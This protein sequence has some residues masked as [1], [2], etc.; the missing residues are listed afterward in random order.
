MDAEARYHSIQ[1]AI[2]LLHEARD[3]LKEAKAPRATEKVRRALKSA[4]GALRHADGMCLGARSSIE[5][6]PNDRASADGSRVPR[7]DGG[8]ERQCQGR[9]RHALYVGAPNLCLSIWRGYDG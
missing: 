7:L 6:R 9:F 5:R 3:R 1:V 8:H 2:G 4:E